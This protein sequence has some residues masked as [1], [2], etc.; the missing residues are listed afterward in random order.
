MTTREYGCSAC[1]FMIRSEEEDELIQ[2]VQD[3]AEDVHDMSMSAGDI[4]EGWTTA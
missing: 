1:D 4:R 3:H 2:M